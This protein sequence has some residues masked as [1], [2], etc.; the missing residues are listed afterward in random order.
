MIAGGLWLAMWNGR[1]RL[2]G[3]VPIALGAVGAA[4]APSPDLLVTGDGKHLA[5]VA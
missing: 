4:M 1:V 3:L 5:V 2:L